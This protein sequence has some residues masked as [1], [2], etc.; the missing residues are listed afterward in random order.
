MIRRIALGCLA[1]VG[2]TA[3]G[4][5]AHAQEHDANGLGA[6][7]QLILSA[8]RLVP[9]LGYSS[10]S[11]SYTNGN[12]NVTSTDKGTSLV[13]MA[14]TEPQAANVHTLPR[15][16]FDFTVIDRLTLGGSI[17]LAFGL[18]GSHKDETV[19]GATTTREY[20]TPTR[21]LIGISPRVGYILPL[22]GV[23]GLWLR[24]GISFYSDK[25]RTQLLANNNTVIVTRSDTDSTLSLDLDPQL[26]IV[27]VQHFFFNV[28]PLVNIPL[29]GSRSHEEPNDPVRKYDL[30]IF[31]LGVSAGLGGWFDL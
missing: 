3:F 30:S 20:D 25:T 26:A 4:A 18:S 9:V 21:T 13:L 31:H 11:V 16:G 2:I 17:L 14:G 28:G 24:G 8:D 6:K 10:V 29:T 5:T 22:T 1:A 12:T 15:V 23:L 7:G 27:P 19:A